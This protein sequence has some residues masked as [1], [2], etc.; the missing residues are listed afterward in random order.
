[1]CKI[2]FQTAILVSL[3]TELLFTCADFAVGF[4]TEWQQVYIQMNPVNAV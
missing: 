4:I 3:L 1:M 2:S